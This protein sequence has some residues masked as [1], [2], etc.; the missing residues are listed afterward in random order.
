VPRRVEGGEVGLVLV[1]MVGQFRK[2]DTK[3]R[4]RRKVLG[5]AGGGGRIDLTFALGIA[6]K[7]LYVPQVKVITGKGGGVDWSEPKL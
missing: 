2:V 3:T 1:T 7:E 5:F 6:E 4:K